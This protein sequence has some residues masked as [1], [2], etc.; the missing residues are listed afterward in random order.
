[1]KNHG[2]DVQIQDANVWMMGRDIQI[3]N[4]CVKI[5][6]LNIE[7]EFLDS[8]ILDLDDQILIW[9]LGPT[10]EAPWCFPQ[11]GNLD[12]SHFATSAISLNRIWTAQ[13]QC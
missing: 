8:K 2:V 7:I 13:V 10:S 3:P 6:D 4:L 1:M 9:T 12:T 11:L 5:L